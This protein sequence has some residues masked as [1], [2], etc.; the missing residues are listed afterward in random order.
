MPTPKTRGPG[1]PPARRRLVKLVAYV[2]PAV[3]EAAR[4]AAERTGL[5]SVSAL[6]SQIL[7][8]HLLSGQTPATRRCRM[9]FEQALRWTMAEHAETF[10]KLAE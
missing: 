1:R 3:L 10:R 9:S 7:S 5:P 6:A 2:D 4:G 8:T